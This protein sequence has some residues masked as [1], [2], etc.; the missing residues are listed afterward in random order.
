MAKDL[1]TFMFIPA[2]DIHLFCSFFPV[3]VKIY[4]LDNTNKS[5]N[6][7]TNQ[8]NQFNQS[9]NQS[10]LTLHHINSSSSH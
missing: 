6:Q 7:P 9:T 8:F 4:T 10:R 2:I 5:T 3:F 1:I